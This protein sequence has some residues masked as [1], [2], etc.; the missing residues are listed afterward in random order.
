MCSVLHGAVAAWR[1]RNS[2][3]KSKKKYARANQT[4]AK[5]SILPLVGGHLRRR[6]RVVGP[7]ARK[8]IWR[9]TNCFVIVCCKVYCAKR[10]ENKQKG[11]FLEKKWRKNL[12]VNK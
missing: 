3:R 6:K 7:S 11:I 12:E 8:C 5:T 9:E 2:E 1:S 4:R 10:R